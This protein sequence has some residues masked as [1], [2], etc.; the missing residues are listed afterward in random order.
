[1]KPQ[2]L[3]IP[4][5]ESTSH[6]QLNALLCITQ[7]LQPY[8]ILPPQENI[9][10]EPQL[11]GGTV[12]AAAT[13]FIKTCAKIDDILADLTR[14]SLESQDALYDALVRTQEQQ[15]A[16]LKAQTAAAESIVRPSFQLKPVL[17]LV[18]NGYA[19]VY[20]DLTTG[21]SI[22]GYGVTPEAAFAD[23]DLAWRRQAIE[24]NVIS[25]VEPTPTAPPAPEV[26]PKRKKK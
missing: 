16:F 1:M 3:P 5:R 19:A 8:L 23:F 7:A 4:S 26:K 13:T 20:G 11:D 14:W 10:K 21:A 6:G 18:D 25:P 17:V 12:A 24:Q 9:P 15:Q 22:V 2:P